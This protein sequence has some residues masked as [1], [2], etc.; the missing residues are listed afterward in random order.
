M[1]AGNFTGSGLCNTNL[2]MHPIDEDGGYN[3]SCD[4]YLA[5]W[6][7]NASG[8]TWS[9]GQNNGCPLD[10]VNVTSFTYNGSVLP[11]LKTGLEIYLR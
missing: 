2:Y 5:G 10:D 6:T 7:N 11:W 9:V 4:P 3:S 1:T 8:P